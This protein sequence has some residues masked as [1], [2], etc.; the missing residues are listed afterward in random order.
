LTT[1]RRMPATSNRQL[2]VR[3]AVS[4]AL[5]RAR[6][7]EGV[8]SAALD[9]LTECLNVSRASV[10]LFDGDGVMRFKAYRGLSSDYR[11]AVEGHSPWTPDSVDAEPF[12]VPDVSR[13][14]SLQQY[15]PVFARERVVALAFIPL[16]SLGRVIG[17][18]M[19]YYD[20]P[21]AFDAE[22]VQLASVIAAAVAFA[23]EPGRTEKVAHRIEASAELEPNAAPLGAW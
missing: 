8:Y 12:L 23:V 19:L 10:L 1:T 3:L 14:P 7:L 15:L 16:V 11:A 22:E 4:R 2:A 18:F 20:A 9:T 13:E 21:H 17:K 6:D 5:G